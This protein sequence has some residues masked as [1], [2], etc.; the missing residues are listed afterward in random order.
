[1]AAEASKKALGEAPAG[2]TCNQPSGH[3][4]ACRTQNP[5]KR[6]QVRRLQ[7]TLNAIITNARQKGTGNFQALALQVDGVIGPATTATVTAIGTLALREASS[8]AIDSK[9]KEAINTPSPEAVAGSVGALL[10]FFSE[11]AKLMGATVEQPTSSPATPADV[12]PLPPAQD[13]PEQGGI[14]KLWWVAGG[15]LLLGAT[16]LG[17]RMYK[18]GDLALAGGGDE[19][20]DDYGYSEA[21]GDFIDV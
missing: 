17:Y 19:D 3:V 15:A 7:T 6:E 9:A 10:V 20:D 13:D 8:T 1:M 5:K 12:Q 11:V 2:F 14:N 4:Y 18:G 21:A 16:Y